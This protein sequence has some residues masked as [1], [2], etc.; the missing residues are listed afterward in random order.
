MLIPPLI[1]SFAK[2]NFM[3]LDLYC[4][5]SCL[6]LSTEFPFL[7]RYFLQSKR[8]ILQMNFYGYHFKRL[9]LSFWQQS[10]VESCTLL[11]KMDVMDVW[12]T[13]SSGTWLPSLP[14]AFLQTRLPLHGSSPHLFLS[15]SRII[16]FTGSSIPSSHNVTAPLLVVLL[17]SLTSIPCYS[18]QWSILSSVT[19]CSFRFTPPSVPSTSRIPISGDLWPICWSVTL[20]LSAFL[21]SSFLI[22]SPWKRWLLQAAI[23]DIPDKR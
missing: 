20:A 23:L 18:L 22:L 13:K 11:L 16:H 21:F 1:S 5:R 3:H 14:E 2:L 15:S 8:F 9:F 6:K 7:Q 10:S 17:M 19:A 12:L 4:C